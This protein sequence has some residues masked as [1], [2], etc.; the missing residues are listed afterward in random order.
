MTFFVFV[1]VSFNFNISI[2]IIS[3]LV[4]IDYAMKFKMINME[5]K[6]NAYLYRGNKQECKYR[7]R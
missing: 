6:N 3:I 7:R 4:F 2:D 1:H 5:E